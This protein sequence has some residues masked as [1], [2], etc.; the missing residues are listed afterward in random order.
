MKPMS[1]RVLLAFACGLLIAGAAL[2]PAPRIVGN[3]AGQVLGQVAGQVAKQVATAAGDLGPGAAIAEEM[4]FEPVSADSATTLER[5]RARRTSAASVPAAPAIPAVPPLPAVPEAPEPPSVII[6]KS[7]DIMRVGSDVVVGKDDVV[8]GDVL[9]VG[10]DLTIEGHVEGNA[11]SMGGDIYLQPGARVDGDVVCMG[12][13]LHEESGAVVG[14]KRVVGL[15]GKNSRLGREYARKFDIDV[16]RDERRAENKLG[17]SLA[18]L[19]VWLMIGWAIVKITPGR[20]AAAL[21]AYRRGPGASFL[22]GWLALVLTVPGLIAVALL[23]ALLCITIIGIPLGIAVL[24]GYFLFLAVFVVW[25]SVVGASVIGEHL[26]MRQGFLTPTLMRA[27]ITGLV[28]LNGGLFA[29]R[30]IQVIP[31]MGGLG[32]FFWVI[33]L[34]ANIMIAVAGWGAL[35]RS[36]FTTGILARW[37]HGRRSGPTPPTA[38]PPYEPAPVGP[39]PIGSGPGGS[40]TSVT[41]VTVPPSPS[42]PAPFSSLMPAAPP[43]PPVPPVPPASPPAAFMPPSEP[44]PPASPSGS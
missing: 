36:E 11:V 4:K 44:P 26:A 20:T 31:M 39:G 24:F 8:T 32:K 19:L 33:L 17:K 23:T 5:R 16:D 6:G 18:W 7:G 21:E 43:A 41:T 34:L 37:W 38:P 3:I 40:G 14:G 2:G 28:V 12:G 25:G 15:G 10:G 1:R 13:E 30:L 27:T 29:A 35:L 9:A 42:A 22:V